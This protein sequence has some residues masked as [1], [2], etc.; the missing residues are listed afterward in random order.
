MVKGW[1][2]LILCQ[3]K[4]IDS[5]L[6]GLLK[7]TNHWLLFVFWDVCIWHRILFWNGRALTHSLHVLT[8]FII[9]QE[10]YLTIR[11]HQYINWIPPW[12]LYTSAANILVHLPVSYTHL[13]NISNIQM[14]LSTVSYTHLDVYKRQVYISGTQQLYTLF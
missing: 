3:I 10:T 13:D 4:N 1:R 7:F 11:I 12:G 2:N 9:K 5:F 14:Y 6:T 8:V